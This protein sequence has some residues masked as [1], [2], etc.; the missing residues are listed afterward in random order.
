MGN[1]FS[2]PVAFNRVHDATI[3]QHIEGRNFSGYVKDLIMQDIRNQERRKAAREATNG[4]RRV[5]QTSANGG[6]KIQL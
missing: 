4:S 2:R 1:R 3:L 5:M 6:I